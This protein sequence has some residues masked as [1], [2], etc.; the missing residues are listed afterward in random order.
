MLSKLHGKSDRKL[1]VVNL[2]LSPLLLLLLG[3]FYYFEDRMC[4]LERNYVW[5]NLWGIFLYFI[6]GRGCTHLSV[7]DTAGSWL[8]KEKSL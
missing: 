3:I 6:E 7:V 2:F 1:L 8:V 5:E 4:S